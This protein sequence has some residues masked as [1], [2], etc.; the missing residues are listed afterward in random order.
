VCCLDLDE[1]ATL[2]YAKNSGRFGPQLYVSVEQWLEDHSRW[3]ITKHA[4]EAYRV[5]IVG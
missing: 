3:P 4:V 5:G 2:C 1:L